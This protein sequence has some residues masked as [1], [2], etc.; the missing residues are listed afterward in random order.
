M[1]SLGNILANAD[2][3]VL[4]VLHPRCEVS[5]FAKSAVNFSS[6]EL[7]DAMSELGAK[8]VQVDFLGD[9]DMGVGS[10][11]CPLISPVEISFF[12]IPNYCMVQKCPEE[13]ADLLKNPIPFVKLT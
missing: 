3:S 2:S 8:L 5:I 1:I 4:Q 6:E 12:S 11:C 7:K 9:H 13:G 10:F